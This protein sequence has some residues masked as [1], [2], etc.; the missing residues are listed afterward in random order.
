MSVIQNFSDTYEILDKLGEGAG[1]IVYK[2]YHKRLRQEVVIKQHRRSAV[3]LTGSRREV[4]ILKN[5]HH[6][7]LPQVLDFF[8]IDG[9][10][11]TVMSYV[12]G[13]SFAQLLAEGY[14]FTPKEL[15]RWGMQICSALNYLHSQNPPVIHCDIKPAN[16][17]LTPRG[18]IC[19]IDFNISFYLGDTAVLGYTNGYTS[20]EQYIMALSHE[21]GQNEAGDVHID[22]RTDIYSVGATLYHLAVGQKV[23]DYRERI[24]AE[25]LAQF[26]GD[27]F[28]QVIERALRIDP[29]QRYQSA[30]DMF[31]ALE[32][33]PK[34]D[35]RYLSLLHRQTAVRIVLVV[36]LAGFIVLGGYGISRIKSERVDAYNGLVEE[37]ISLIEAGDYEGQEQVFEEASELLPSSLESYYQNAYSLYKQEKFEDCISF[38]EYNIC[39]NEQLDLVQ[40]RMAD[41]YYLRADSYFRLEQYEEAADA[42]EDVFRMGTRHTEYYR[43]YAITLA[44]A[45]DEEEAQKVL[46]EAI[47]YG[48]TEDSVYYAKGEIENALGRQDAAL[49]E[50]KECISIT[51][52]MEMKTRAYLMMSDIYK[53]KGSDASR[54]DVLLEAREELPAEEQLQVLERLASADIELADTTGKKEYREEAIEVLTQIID[55]GWGTFDT[56]DTLA[57]QYEKQGEIEQARKTVDQ[58]LETYGEDY[59][60]YMRYA[61]LEIDTQELKENAQRDYSQFAE[62]Y[63][64]A[65]ELYHEQVK[66]NNTDAQMQLLEDVYGQVKEGGWLE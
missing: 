46:Q 36:L 60:I 6:S 58:M 53:E 40:A 3:S 62:Y 23:G 34:K 61:F 39:Q 26:T 47:D 65:E 37:Q 18:D 5:L 27:S 45:G 56:A 33:I 30:Y 28:A 29:A 51:D 41:V 1:G 7:Y 8:E 20:P 16:I 14:R 24:N 63:E 48:L 15:I 13:K 9:D 55:Q 52:D 10:V 59:R 12:P 49:Q 32:N 50:F 25:Y 17:M 19:L 11:Y 42:Y 66:D 4:D 35:S 57:I 54:R 22:E 31:R 2:A 64:K 21:S 43:D 38:I 44:Y